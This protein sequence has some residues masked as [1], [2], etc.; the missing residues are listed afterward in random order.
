MSD[1]DDR[2][3]RTPPR[4]PPG[5]RHDASPRDRGD[6]EPEATLEE[7][8]EEDIVGD[9]DAFALEPA[10]PEPM[11]DDGNDDRGFDAAPPDDVTMQR[12]SDDN[13]LNPTGGGFTDTPLRE[14]YASMARRDDLARRLEDLVASAREW[15]SQQGSDEAHDI[16]ETLADVYERLGLPTEDTD[17]EPSGVVRAEPGELEEPGDG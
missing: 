11:P 3:R 6:E 15:A 8:R 12:T 13:D 1:R 9:E 17:G 14:E 4:T 2:E 10:S 5:T 16:A 7:M